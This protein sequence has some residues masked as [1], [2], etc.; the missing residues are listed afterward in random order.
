MGEL[1]M[2]WS[3]GGPPMYLLAALGAVLWSGATVVLI[4]ASTRPRTASWAGPALMCI[5]AFGLAGLG[6]ASEVALFRYY[7]AKYIATAPRIFVAEI[8]VSAQAE[9]IVDRMFGVL[10]A[11]PPFAVAAF[12][13]VRRASTGALSIYVSLLVAATVL[14]G[15]L[16]AFDVIADR[17]TH[18]EIEA[19][20]LSRR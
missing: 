2:L 4:Q 12:A 6:W 8:R 13:G 5:G 11:T 18:L 17:K 3:K 20:S 14:F 19:N 16:A 10:L 9:A 15:G 1:E 7:D